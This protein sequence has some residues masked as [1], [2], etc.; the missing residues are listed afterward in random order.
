MGVGLK[1]ISFCGIRSEGSSRHS[2]DATSKLVP[3]TKPT[4]AGAQQ[5]PR[6][7][8]H[9]PNHV[10]KEKPLKAIATN[11]FPLPSGHSPTG[12][13]QRARSSFGTQGVAVTAAATAA[14]TTTASA[15]SAP[16]VS[17]AP[18]AGTR[19]FGGRRYVRRRGRSKLGR[20]AGST[21]IGQSESKGSGLDVTMPPVLASS[22]P[23]GT[24]RP[25]TPTRSSN[26]SR[27]RLRVSGPKRGSALEVV[28]SKL[29]AVTDSP[30]RTPTLDGDHERKQ[31]PDLQR[32]SSGS[33]IGELAGA[34][35]GKLP[36]STRLAPVGAAGGM[37][38]PMADPLASV[39]PIAASAS[40]TAASR[41][42]FAARRLVPR[43]LARAPVK[44][45][46]G[47]AAPAQVLPATAGASSPNHALAGLRTPSDS[48]DGSPSSQWSKR[49]DPVEYHSSD[50]EGAG[51]AF[52][53][54]DCKEDLAED[55]EAPAGSAGTHLWPEGAAQVH[56]ESKSGSG[57]GPVAAEGKEGGGETL[58]AM[59]SGG[60]QVTH[61]R[62]RARSLLRQRLDERLALPDGSP[63]PRSRP[64]KG[65]GSGSA[66]GAEAGGSAGVSLRAANRRSNII[67]STNAPH[68]G[69]VRTPVGHS[70]RPLKSGNQMYRDVLNNL[71][72]DGPEASGSTVATAA[73]PS[74]ADLA[75]PE[76]SMGGTGV[77]GGS[78][79]AHTPASLRSL[80]DLMFSP[81][82]RDAS[83]SA[84]KPR[85][86]I[87]PPAAPT[88]RAGTDGVPSVQ[89]SLM[90][91]TGTL[92]FH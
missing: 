91:T 19:P 32:T 88:K 25:T 47:G 59:V 44:L 70:S 56:Q 2:T 49:T 34:G 52:L 5:R 80:A 22:R 83:G 43:R 38:L 13:A 42:N 14:P 51:T 87:V 79:L 84:R 69:A 9:A 85:T 28:E 24:I 81:S 23:K 26:G 86:T 27:R 58:D 3:L 11:L 75:M 48:P 21:D 10:P 82:M 78:S 46:V 1:H 12:N 17:V 40:P 7:V 73:T 33:S 92:V 16:S 20:T 68:H 53:T 55:E 15:T 64:M 77:S 30:A 36:P 62:A 50:E 18:S 31:Q 61:V 54:Y 63:A 29:A 76:P 37:S 72:P 74:H 45:E 35:V 39:S 71:F 89:S 8:K 67:A 90:A 4:A 6:P 66:A 57:A 65:S 41:P 60:G